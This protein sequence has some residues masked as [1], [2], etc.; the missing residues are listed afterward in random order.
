MAH[1]QNLVKDIQ[2]RGN[3]TVNREAILSAMSLKVGA[4]YSEEK[5]VADQQAI[6]DLGFFKAVRIL[7]VPEGTGSDWTVRV[8]VEEYPTIKEIRVSGNS[9]VKTQDIVAKLP[10]SLQPGHIFNLNERRAATQAIVDLYANKSYLADVLRFEPLEGSP[11]TLNIEI[12]ETRVGS[13]YVQGNKVTQDR[14]IRRL[15]RTRPGDVYSKDRWRTD[16][17]RLYGTGWF[18]DINTDPTP[19]TEIGVVDLTLDLKEARTGTFNVGLQ[20]DP[21]NSLAG[22]VRYSQANVGGTGRSFGV[23][24][25]QSTQGV[26]PSIDLDYTDP[27]IDDKNTTLRASIYSRVIFRFQGGLFGSGNT[28]FTRDDQYNERRSG[29][30]IGFSRPFKGENSSIGVSLRAE[31]VKTE[32]LKPRLIDHDGDPDTDKIPATNFIQQDGQVSVATFGLTQDRRDVPIDASRGDWSQFTIEPGYSN[33][34]RVGGITSDSSIIGPNF[35]GKASFEYRRYFSSGPPRGFKLDEPRKVLA[36]R[37]RGG[38]ILGDT[39][40]FEQ[41]FAGG[42]ESVRG[43]QEDRFWGRQMFTSTMEYRFP[44]QKAFS[45]VAFVDYGGAWGG[46]GSVNNFTQSD[47]FKLHLGYGPGVSFKAGPLGNIQ[48]Y[49]GFNEQGK[50]RTHF[51]IGN[52]F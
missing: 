28:S 27:F 7:G 13:I 32:N 6:Q 19:G 41:Y 20:L 24:F 34:R 33:I 10:T 15:I 48:L 5:R 44:I 29:G 42:S 35:F 47:Q 36:F 26:G 22:I 46:Y 17:T 11:G 12:V 9:V 37:I 49:L 51:L 38:S 25:L 16:L 30:S 1:A 45:L 43:Y 2:V 8:D 39:P 18:D 52:S 14:T 21:R 3:A 4:V 40:F 50:S 23:N 31:D